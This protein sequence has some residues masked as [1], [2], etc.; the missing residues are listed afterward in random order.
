MTTWVPPYPEAMVAGYSGYPSGAGSF[1]N[2]DGADSSSQVPTPFDLTWVAGDTAFFQFFFVGVCWTPTEPTDTLGLTWVATSWESQVRAKY[3]TYYNYWWPPTW[4]G[5]R[6]LMSF[7]VTAELLTD[8]VLGPGTMVTLNG[9][10]IWPGEFVWDLQTKQYPDP[11][12]LA[13]Y[14]VRTWRSGKATVMAQVTQDDRYPPS[15][16]PMIH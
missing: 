16:W 1:V 10:T 14:Y 6:Y 11:L 4:P 2:G 3:Y 7:A 13:H 5:Y 8:P 12:D 15:N 9:G